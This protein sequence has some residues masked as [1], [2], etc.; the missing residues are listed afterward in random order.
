MNTDFLR[1]Q[2]RMSG[3]FLDQA[4]TGITHEASLHPTPTGQTINW[5]IGHLADARGGALALLS[6]DRTWPDAEL[7]LYKR[8]ADSLDPAHALPLSELT[9]RFASVQEPL[10]QHLKLLTDERAAQK[11]PFSPSGNPD[12]TV[13][14]LMGVLA[15]HEV[16]HVGQVGLLR[17]W[18]GLARVV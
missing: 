4:L 14:S 8:G 13:G 15:F 16:Y 17:R 1:A 3:W 12:E 6:G 7:A 9:R 10:L 11:A 18:A 2:L 5:L